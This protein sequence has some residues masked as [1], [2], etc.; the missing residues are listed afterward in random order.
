[1]APAIIEG[2]QS[3]FVDAEG[4]KTHYYEAGE[5]HPLVLIHGGGAGADAWGNWRASIGTYAQQFHVFAVDLVGFG[6]SDKPDPANFEYS[7]ERRNQHIIGLIEALGLEKIHLIGNSMGGS[8][9]MG[10]AIERPDLVN[11]LVLMGSAGIKSAPSE[12]LKSIMNYDFTTDGMR[13]IVKGLTNPA[14]EVNEDMVSYRHTLSIE[15]DTRA[16]YGAVMG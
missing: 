9:S 6:H 7:Q 4:I 8:T 2:A 10:V 16:A 3:K 13:K 1:M 11:R 15:D 5:G 12:E 14:F